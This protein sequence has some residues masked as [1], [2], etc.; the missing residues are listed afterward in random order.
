MLTTSAEVSAL[1][2][3]VIYF[4]VA[5]AAENDVSTLIHAV[6]STLRL[7]ITVLSCPVLGFQTS[8]TSFRSSSL[9]W[10]H[11]L[12]IFVLE[13][14]ICNGVMVILK[15][16]LRRFS[17]ACK[18]ERCAPEIV[19]LRF[20]GIPISPLSFF[21]SLYSLYTLQFLSG[22]EQVTIRFTNFFFAFRLGVSPYR[23]T[24]RTHFLARDRFPCVHT[25]VAR[26]KHV[27]TA[28]LH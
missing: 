27:L 15:I 17:R 11:C 22:S 3:V 28:R 4:Q 16:I 8:A 21:R 9:R 13:P 18:I 5:V 24:K 20:L 19:L 7:V 23:S 26:P 2:R 25:S 12:L 6:R 14:M 10:R 1:R